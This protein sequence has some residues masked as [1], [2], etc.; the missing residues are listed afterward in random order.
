MWSWPDARNFENDQAE[1]WHTFDVILALLELVP[2]GRATRPPPHKLWVV[3]HTNNTYTH[4]SRT[5]IT[6]IITSTIKRGEPVWNTQCPFVIPL[7][8][9]ADPAGRAT[10]IDWR[11]EGLGERRAAFFSW[12]AL[13]VTAD[14][15][16]RPSP[17]P[18]RPS[19]GTPTPHHARPRIGGWWGGWGGVSATTTSGRVPP[20]VTARVVVE[21][22]NKKFKKK[23]VSS[24]LHSRSYYYY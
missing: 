4:H 23:P 7:W 16:A 14:I 15:R 18:R 11:R 17:R 5:I 2:S 1:K 3:F 12:S 6:T 19:Y 13:K 24:R 8:S 20:V 21:N 22:N 10:V 9:S